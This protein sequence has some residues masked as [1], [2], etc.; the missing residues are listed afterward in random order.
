MLS[1]D[2]A[3]DLALVKIDVPERA[4]PV[5]P[6]GTSCDLMRGETVDRD[7]QRVRLRGNT[8]TQGDRLRDLFRDVEVTDTQS[9]R[10][11]IQTDA[12][13]NPGNSGGPLINVRGEVIGINVAIRAGAQ[14]IG[15]AIPHRRRPRG[16]GKT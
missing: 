6:L 1:T 7:R 4:L 5:M 15:F 13:I 2:P 10:N 11:L 14:R 9:Y 8:V 3:H 16:P 12:G